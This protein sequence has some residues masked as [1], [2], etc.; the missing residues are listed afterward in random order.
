M[1]DMLSQFWQDARIMFFHK[2]AEERN[3]KIQLRG[4]ILNIRMFGDRDAD[5][6]DLLGRIADLIQQGTGDLC[7]D[8]SVIVIVR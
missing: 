3:L 8:T 5:V 4:R 1:T 6:F 7:A 2:L